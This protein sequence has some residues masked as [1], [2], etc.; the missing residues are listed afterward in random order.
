M[1]ERMGADDSVEEGEIAGQAG[2][3]GKD[4]RRAGEGREKGDSV[5]KWLM[6]ATFS[7]IMQSNRQRSFSL[8]LIFNL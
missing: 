1:T 4:G 6:A 3:D 8:C 7:V 5:E 2:N